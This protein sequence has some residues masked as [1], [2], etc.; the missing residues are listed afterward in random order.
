MLENIRFWPGEEAK[1]NDFA[2][3]IADLGDIYV[4]DCFATSHRA[5]STMLFLPKFLPSYSGITLEKEIKELSKV[6]N[7]PYRPLVAIIGGAKLGV[8][9]PVIDNLSKIADRVLIC[10]K[11]MFEIESK[12]ISKNVVVASDDIDKNDIGPKSIKN[13][14]EIISQAKMVV[15]N[16][17]PGIFEEE[18][19]ELG[20]KKI[21]QALVKPNIY[22][23]VGGGDTIEA[24]NKYGFLDKINYVS[25]GGGAMLV[26][27][28]GKKLPGIEALG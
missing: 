3:Q 10:G 16:G 17:P 22:S 4:N 11:L 12:D 27:L 20:T 6:I 26:L 25:T 15:W 28:S 7:E 1:D 13:F 9:L 8:K 21:A 24:L 23:V 5:F 14:I 18:K 19:Y 2:S